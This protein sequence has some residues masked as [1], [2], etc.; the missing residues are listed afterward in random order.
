MLSR[1]AFTQSVGVS[2]RRH[3]GTFEFVLPYLDVARFPR[4]IAMSDFVLSVSARNDAL[5][6][7]DGAPREA[8]PKS[9]RVG[10]SPFSISALGGRYRRKARRVCQRS[11]R[12]ALTAH[13]AVEQKC[14]APPNLPYAYGLVSD[15][16]NERLSKLRHKRKFP[17][18]VYFRTT[19]LPSPSETP[20][21]P[22]G[23]QGG[24]EKRNA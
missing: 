19:P 17:H 15:E 7:P 8:F 14:A 5:T 11:C 13:R 20:T 2:P 4:G 16:T 10:K 22:R 18:G 6:S 1:I 21:P 12:G 24:R 3:L 9:L 23:G